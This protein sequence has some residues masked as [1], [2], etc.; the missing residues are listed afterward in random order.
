MATRLAEATLTYRQRLEHLQ[1]TK[2][3]HTRTKQQIIGAMDYDDWA[4]IPPPEEMRNVA[5]LIGPSG[6]PI[7]D[8]LFKG[9]EMESNHPS[10]GFFGSGLVGRNYRRLLEFHPVYIDPYGSLAG[11]YMVNFFSTRQPHWNPELRYDHLEPEQEMYGLVTGIGGV[12][13][14]AQDLSIGL[15]LGW[16][17]LLEKINKYRTNNGPEKKDFYDGLEDVVLGMQ[18]LIRRHAEEAHRL[19]A[20]QDN[21]Q[22]RQNLHEMAEINDWLVDNTPRTFREACQWILWYQMAARMYDGSGSLGRLDLYL[23]P[24]Y[25]KDV[26]EGRLTDQEAIFHVAQN[27]LRVSD[28][29]QLGGY[30]ERGK[31]NTNPVSLLVLE[32]AHQLRIPANIAVAV[33]QGID[34][35][36][37]KRGVEI[38]F[39]D[40]LGIPKFLGLDPLYRDYMKNG[41]S[42]EEA[43]SRIYNGCHWFA[44]PGREYGMNDLIKLNFAKVF[45]VALREML[46][47]SAVKPSLAELWKRFE[48]HL[49]RAV[50]VLAEGLDFHMEH[51][52]EV[53]PELVLDLLCYGPIEKGRDVSQSGTLDYV[54]LCIDGSALATTADSFAAL[55]QRIEEEKRTSWQELLQQLD[56][57]WSAPEGPK[58]RAM[59]K[60]VPHYG[61]GGSKGDAYAVRIVQTFARIVEEKP[62]PKG[63]KMIPG[64]FS[65]ASTLSM[66][67]KLGATPNGRRAGEPISFGSNPDPGFR[68]DGALTALAEAVAAVQP[69]WGNPA[70]LQIEVDPGFS[71]EEGGIDKICTLMETHFELGGTVIN[72]NIL[73][74]EKVLAAHRDPSKYPDLVVRVTGFSA[75]FASLSPEMREVVV[76]RIVTS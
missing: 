36:L 25:R 41:Y 53:F 76:K 66:G 39:E 51:M 19:A 13:H 17:G 48:K 54:N 1:E 34:R 35:A 43:R 15:N 49:G 28:Y 74:K 52:H 5:T 6:E 55:E 3:I 29:I 47:D 21:E 70:P 10:G 75:Y 67:K 42:I 59:M 60:N 56:S 46:S 31:D 65:W 11:G 8:I 58:V 7:T 44:I 63:H 40:K 30:D 68:K 72:I 69:G 38:L 22:L 4:V 73:D 61:F 24:Y 18:N 37:L 64:L 9:L 14:L 50:D 27:L 20:D 26:E 71:K 45:D 32:A 33:G 12:Q 62:T 23:Y 2:R 57:D 16:K